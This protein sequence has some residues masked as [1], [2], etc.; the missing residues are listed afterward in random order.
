MFRHAIPALALA[1]LACAAHAQTAPTETTPAP[2]VA[3][4]GKLEIA[5]PFARA[6]LPN[7]PV[8]GGYLTITNTGETDDTLVGVSSA[9]ADRMEIHEMAMEGDVMQMRELADG[10]PI[11]AGGTV[12]LA[13]GGYHVMFM[14]LAGPLAEGD[15]V[16]LTLRFAEA[17]EV[18]VAMPV[19]GR[20]AV[21]ATDGE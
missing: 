21:S 10:L 17:G 13:P 7:Q 14:D 6:T 9:A 1:A 2:T 15:A 19:L 5:A 11:P 4:L 3:T 12:T 16:A 18:S 20:T 8:A